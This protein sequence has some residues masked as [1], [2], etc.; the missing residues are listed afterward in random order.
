MFL[1]YV[2]DVVDA[3]VSRERDRM[4]GDP[5]FSMKFIPYMIHCLSCSVSFVQAISQNH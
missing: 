1:L 4:R 5:V 2:H 3:V